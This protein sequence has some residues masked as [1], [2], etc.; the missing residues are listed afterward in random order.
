[1]N[2]SLILIRIFSINITHLYHTLRWDI[3]TTYDILKNDIE[4]E[5][6]HT[7]SVIALINMIYAKVFFFN[8]EMSINVLAQDELKEHC[9]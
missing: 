5:N 7:T 3:E 9:K 6:V 2:I 4:I 1:M 8:L